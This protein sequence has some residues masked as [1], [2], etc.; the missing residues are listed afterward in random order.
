M[1]KRDHAGAWRWYA[2]ARNKL[3]AARP[4]QNW[5]EFTQHVGAPENSRV[6]EYLC[7]KQL[8]R[9]DEANAKWLE[10]EQNFFPPRATEQTDAAAPDATD[11]WLGALGPQAELLK[12]LIH[13]LYVAEVFLSVDA[14]DDALT[15]F[16]PNLPPTASQNAEMTRA[17]VLG[18][19]FLVASDHDGY[20]SHC[21]SVVA[22]LAIEMGTNAAKHPAENAHLVLQV[23]AGLCV[24]PLFRTDFLSGVSDAALQKN[25][26]IWKDLRE[27]LGDGLPAVAVDLV[28]RAAALNRNDQTAAK[29]A[30][31]RIARNPAGR[32]L[33]AHQP[34][35]EVLAGWMDVAQL[36]LVPAA[37]R[38]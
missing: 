28:L 2:Q 29:V 32:D 23:A 35:D 20:L 21:T 24:A 38:P 10:F 13:D 4:P 5:T 22:P 9:D 26:P 6:F 19:L 33:F 36:S 34:I 8:G 12:H 31:E 25:I 7:L 14:V 16:R 15:H 37:G 30:E 11:A 3:P 27:R 18:Q 17:I 1:L